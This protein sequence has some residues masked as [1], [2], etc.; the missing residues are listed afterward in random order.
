MINQKFNKIGSQ[1]DLIISIIK[2][3][4]HQEGSCL[5]LI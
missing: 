3:I 1:V 2:E 4:K 5:Q